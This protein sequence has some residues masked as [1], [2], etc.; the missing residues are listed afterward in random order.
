MLHDASQQLLMD[1]LQLATL[2]DRLKLSST[3]QASLERRVRVGSYVTIA[4]PDFKD[5]LDVQIVDPGQSKPAHSRISYFS[6]L[7][8]ALLGL[9][10]GAELTV[11]TSSKPRGN[12]PTASTQQKW[13]ITDVRQHPGN[14]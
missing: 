2:L 11:P 9:R 3:P 4:S 14:F 13:I 12:K 10:L 6:P 5:T 1:D 8:S 7:G